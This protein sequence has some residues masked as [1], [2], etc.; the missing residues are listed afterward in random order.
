MYFMKGLF[1]ASCVLVLLGA[2]CSGSSK[3]YSKEM[4]DKCFA[5]TEYSPEENAWRWKSENAV[6]E[7]NGGYFSSRQEAIDNC[8][9]S[10][11]A[12]N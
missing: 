5:W 9:A 6:K 10:F 3:T 2:G 4:Q 8:L 11:Q 1:L 7:G 12:L